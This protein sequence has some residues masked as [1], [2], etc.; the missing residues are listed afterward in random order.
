MVC[1]QQ[2][3]GLIDGLL[4]TSTSLSSHACKIVQSAL[5]DGHLTSTAP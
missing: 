4:S 2:V 3:V 5:D 1:Y